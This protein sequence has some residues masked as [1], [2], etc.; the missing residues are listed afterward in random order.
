VEIDRKHKGPRNELLACVWLL[1]RGYE[2]FRN[3][4]NHGLIDVV[5]LK[6]S[7]VL[8][9]DVKVSQQRADGSLYKIRITDN[10]K[11]MGVKPIYVL[12]TGDCIIDFEPPTLAELHA[13][14]PCV[15][16]NG[17]FAPSNTRQQFCSLECG[18]NSRAS[19]KMAC[20]P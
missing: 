9:L 1:N 4:S 10:Q 7:E 11:A 2:V 19:G 6:G 15:G 13:G 20:S 5:A 16:C 14:R 12:P 3:V 17:I 8:L 18:V